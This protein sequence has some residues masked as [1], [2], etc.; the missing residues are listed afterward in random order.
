MT[1]YYTIYQTT[2]LV[3]NKIYIGQ[4]KTTNPYDDYIGSGDTFKDA[5]KKY[6]N[7][8]FRKDIL[9]IY[10]NEYDMDQKEIELVTEEFIARDDNYN[11]KPGGHNGGN[12]EESK[13][14]MRKPKSEKARQNMSAAK[15]GKKRKPHSEETKAKMS[16]AQ[17]GKTIS[18]EAKLNMSAA[19]KGHKRSKES[20]EKTAASK[21]GRKQSEEH[22]QKRVKSIT[23]KKRSEEAKQNMRKP[24]SEKLKQKI[25]DLKSGTIW[26][27][28]GNIC[29]MIPG[30][31]T[32]PDGFWKGRIINK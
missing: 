32:I 18:E 31:S 1:I 7:E 10:D 24:R 25:S 15:R 14:K 23:G 21:R 13:A 9:F 16:L 26:I 20:I 27:T 8:N 11:I 6:G 4:H 28:D 2:N 30:N 17:K 29:K 5:K 3:N 22:I 12:S 19:K